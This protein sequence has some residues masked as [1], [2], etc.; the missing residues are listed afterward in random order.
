MF[1]DMNTMSY[2]ISDNETL[3][4]LHCLMDN[5]TKLGDADAETIKHRDECAEALKEFE[6]TLSKEQF[7]LYR[8]VS[9]NDSDASS[10]QARQAFILGY[11][12]ATRILLESIK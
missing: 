4:H 1:G 8:V 10:L 11:K 2:L 3:S 12:T 7:E 6:S 5:Y 9:D